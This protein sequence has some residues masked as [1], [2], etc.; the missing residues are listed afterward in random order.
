MWPM[1]SADIAESARQPSSLF[2]DQPKIIIASVDLL[3]LNLSI[4]PEYINFCNG[5][6]YRTILLSIISGR[7]PEFER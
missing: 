3:S 6:S 4:V 2:N 1:R 5:T 7:V